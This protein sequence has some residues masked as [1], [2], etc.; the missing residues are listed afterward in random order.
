MASTCPM[1]RTLTE[2]ISESPRDAAGNRKQRRLDDS[3]TPGWFRFFGRGRAGCAGG[4]RAIK[5]LRTTGARDAAG[6]RKQGRLDDSS[7]RVGAGWFRFWRRVRLRRPDPLTNPPGRPPLP[8]MSHGRVA[9]RGDRRCPRGEGRTLTAAV[10]SS[11]ALSAALTASELPNRHRLRA[12]RARPRRSA[13]RGS[14]TCP[15]AAVASPKSQPRGAL[16]ESA[17]TAQS[18]S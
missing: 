13:A 7:T 14:Q 6:N 11:S 16:E 5:H 12:P 4:A 18:S 8:L 15:E 3:S 9:L 1:S 10:A 2:V 17:W